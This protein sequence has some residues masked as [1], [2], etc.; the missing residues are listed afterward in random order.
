MSRF[1]SRMKGTDER[2]NKLGIEDINTP[3]SIISRIT[4]EK[5]SKDTEEVN[6][7][8]NQQD[9][10]NIY[11]TLHPTAVVGS[12]VNGTYTERPHPES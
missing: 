11:K 6:N 3:L 8:I 10:N 2:I 9:L 12:S 7:T 5:I 4:R 1:N